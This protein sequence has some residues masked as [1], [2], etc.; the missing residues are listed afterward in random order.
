MD[1]KV[2]IAWKYIRY[3]SFQLYQQTG[4]NTWLRVNIS[5]YLSLWASNEGF[6]WFK[7]DSYFLPMNFLPPHKACSFWT[8]QL[9]CKQQSQCSFLCLKTLLLYH[10]LCLLF[11]LL[12]KTWG[13]YPS[14]K[15]C[16][17]VSYSGK[18]VSNGQQ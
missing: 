18:I 3:S 13:N 14:I 5:F 16:K 4:G 1:C 7:S 17:K 10:D 11:I 12:A 9:H 6:R 2:L 8:N 15:S